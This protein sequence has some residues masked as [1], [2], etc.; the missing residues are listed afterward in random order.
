M[1]WKIEKWLEEVL[2]GAE[3]IYSKYREL[4]TRELVIAAAA[5]LDNALYFFLDDI[6]VVAR[7]YHE[8]IPQVDETVPIDFNNRQFHL[9]DK[10]TE[11]RIV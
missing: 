3:N 6:E 10:Q 2:P 7:C 8:N 11:K 5:V 4:P 1:T 9:F